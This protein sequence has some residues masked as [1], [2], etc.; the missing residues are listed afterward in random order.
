MIEKKMKDGKEKDKKNLIIILM[1][2]VEKFYQKDAAQLFSLLGTEKYDNG[3]DIDERAMVGCIYRYMHEALEFKKNRFPHIDIEY[4][5]MQR[6][7]G[8]E[9][10]KLIVLCSGCENR[11]AKKGDMSCYMYAKKLKNEIKGNTSNKDISIRPD[12]IIHERNTSNNGLM[13]EFKKL[14][15]SINYDNVKV[16]YATCQTSPLH[17]LVGAVVQLYKK[18][19]DMHIYDNGKVIGTVVFENGNFTILGQIDECQ[20]W[21]KDAVR[22][23][24]L[25]RLLDE[26]EC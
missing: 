15:G 1:R 9:V 21:L 22:F 10:D 2:G 7:N 11:D 13:I 6:I 5:R 4:N 14:N 17:Y 12:I 24:L 16:C 26:K 23:H 19:A 3:K 8:D 25:R 18:S 20:Q